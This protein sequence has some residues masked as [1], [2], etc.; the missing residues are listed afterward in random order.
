[1]KAK[2]LSLAALSLVLPSLAFAQDAAPT[3]VCNVPA[4]AAQTSVTMMGWTFP[5]LDFYASV[6]ESCGEVENIDVNTQLLASADAKEQMRL[7]ASTDGPT[8]D[9]IHGDN[10]FIIEMAEAGWLLPLND[11]IEQ[12]SEEFDL[13]DID[14]N[15]YAAGSI[16]GVIYG[17]PVIVNTQH[18]YFNSAILEEAG[19]AVPTTYDEVIAACETMDREALNIDY[20][21]AMVLS[22]GWA[23]Q[24]EFQNVLSAYGSDVL[25]EN[26]MPVFNGPEGVAAMNKI[27]ELVNACMGEDGLLLSTDDVQAGLR[28][29]SIAMAHMWA[30]RA[31]GM[32]D[33]AITEVAGQIEYAPALFPT[34]EQ[35]VRGGIAWAD[36]LAIPATTEADPELLFQMIMQAAGLESQIAAS[37]FG[38]VSRAGAAD[39][40]PRNFAA[41]STTI[42]EGGPANANP[43]LSVAHAAMGEFLPMVVGG[44]MT[45]QEA[46]DAAAERY[47]E[48]GTA[49]GFISG[50]M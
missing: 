25:D 47:I 19:I 34:S 18:F 38:L 12:Y 29:G 43:A 2:L 1:M 31:N 4:P 37:Q 11:L 24:I 8:Y 20:P 9:I 13:D 36:F 48:E 14:A 45:V 49:Q 46:L 50:G 15:L 33:P 39:A 22:A 27:V 17:I 28:N 35:T 42:A 26:N 3:V 7:A 10:T 23:W 44:T 41:S 32:D 21:F 16:D 40:A 5:I 30:S 6:L